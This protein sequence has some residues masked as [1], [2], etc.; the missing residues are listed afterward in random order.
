MFTLFKKEVVPQVLLA[1]KWRFP[2][3]ITVNIRTS[4]DGGYI[5]NINNFPGCVTQAE[6]GQELFEMIQDAICT[7][8]EIPEE[9]KPYMPTFFPPEELRKQLDTEIPEKYLGNGLIL[10]RI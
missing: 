8:L 6:N 10:Q 2:D 3:K 4:Q 5:A 7:Y 1:F 9:Y